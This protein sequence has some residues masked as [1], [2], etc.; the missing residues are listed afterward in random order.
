MNINQIELRHL[1]Y[2]TRVAAERH[3]GR[4]AE[5]LGIAQPPLSQQI[6][7]L[8]ERLGVRLFDRTTRTVKLTE[9][10][11][12]FLEHALA[13]LAN[14]GEGVVAAQNA[15]GKNAGRLVI[16][17]VHLGPVLFLPEI[18]R[19]FLRRYPNVSIDI[20]ILT[21][22][23]QVEALAAR[24]L[25]IGFVRPPRSLGGLSMVKLSSEG[26]VAVLAKDNPLAAKNGLTLGDLRDEPFLALSPLVGVGYQNVTMQHCRLLGFH[27]RIVQEVSHNLAIVTLAAAGIG[28]GV[29]PAWVTRMPHPDVAYRPLPELPDAVELA[30]VWPADDLSPFIRHFVATT[31]EVAAEGQRP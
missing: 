15:V 8:E 2:F 9:A 6:R 17:A 14:V 27:P 1:R 31:R 29:V 24:K 13:A 12:A 30:L 19:R 16:G 25:N 7:Q 20:R 18:I 21:T 28:V 5:R 26:F 23:E 11:E 22:D 10:G 4:A 3:F